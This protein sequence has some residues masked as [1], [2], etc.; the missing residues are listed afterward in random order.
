MAVEE[1]LA[2]GQSVRQ[3][4]NPDLVFLLTH[5][6]RCTLEIEGRTVEHQPG[7]LICSAGAIRFSSCVGE[8]GP[9]YARYLVMN[10][11]ALA[12]LDADLR[13]RH[14]RLLA[15]D[16]C[17]EPAAALV[18]AVDAAIARTP[19][20]DWAVLAAIGGI[21]RRILSAAGDSDLVEQVR[22]LVDG[23]PER[24]WPLA[25]VARRLELTV[26]ALVH[27]FRLAAGC[28]LSPWIRRRRMDI[29]RRW[30]LEG[31]SVTAVAADLGFSAVAHFSRCF[32]G[33]A[34]V[35]PSRV[36]SGV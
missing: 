24:A 22:L 3:A 36:C 13:A 33:V 16:R 20:W 6:G 35:P 7:R 1:A 12:G 32:R 10:G 26:P 9:W 4:A 14:G 34:G 29:A 18:E 17:G 30:L 25:E 15:L 8:A 19:G 11:P 28:A 5:A 2:P 31:R 23:A 27:R 21:G